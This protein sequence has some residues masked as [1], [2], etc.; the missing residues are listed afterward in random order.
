MDKRTIKRYQIV[1]NYLDNQT[2][3]RWEELI[4]AVL[5]DKGNCE[6][7]GEVLHDFVQVHHHNEECKECG[8]MMI[9]TQ[10]HNHTEK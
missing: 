10:A 7:C 4:Q 5:T 9:S 8:Y 6:I 1:S 3:E 2:Q